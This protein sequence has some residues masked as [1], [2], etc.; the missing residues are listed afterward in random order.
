[1]PSSSTGGDIFNIMLFMESIVA[2]DLLVHGVFHVILSSYL[3][4]TNTTMHH[5]QLTRSV[6]SADAA[7]FW[8]F[9]ITLYSAP[10]L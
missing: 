9:K 5:N 6:C 2:M 4:D 8:I 3:S 1:M 10:K 7:N